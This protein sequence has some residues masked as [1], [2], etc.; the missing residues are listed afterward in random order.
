MTRALA[1]ELAK[2][3]I[4]VNCINPGPTDTPMMYKFIPEFNDEIKKVIGSGTPL[5]CWVMP[6]DVA[7]AGLFLDSDEASKIT[8]SDLAVDSGLRIGRSEV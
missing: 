5:G 3:K 6:E 7:Y 4:Q 1:V 2:Y 8:G